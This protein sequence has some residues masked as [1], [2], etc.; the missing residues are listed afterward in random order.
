M[1][2][3]SA[4]SRTP[5]V[6]ALKRGACMCSCLAIRV[7]VETGGGDYRLV[8]TS[9]TE[10]VVSACVARSFATWAYARAFRDASL[11]S[12]FG[13]CAS[14]IGHFYTESSSSGSEANLEEVIKQD[15]PR[16]SPCVKSIQK[17]SALE[18]SGTAAPDPDGRT[19]AA[20]TSQLPTTTL[21]CPRPRRCPC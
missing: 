9:D 20:R 1:K 2:R 16:I 13:H 8:L 7:D 17:L 5:K 4:S 15:F 10:E 19:R 21:L 6:K 18:A 12:E 11:A 14:G 3:C